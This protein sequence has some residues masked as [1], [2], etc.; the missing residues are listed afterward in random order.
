MSGNNVV[1]ELYASNKQLNVRVNT[2]HKKM[3]NDNNEM[4]TILKDL[5]MNLKELLEQNKKILEKIEISE[6]TDEKKT[7]FLNN[8]ISI[9]K[10][11]DE[12]KY[13]NQID[14]KNTNNANNL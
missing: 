13:I 4:I 6:G 5:G 11:L 10:T 14:I 9:D 1:N 8:K 12:L 3:E 7:F 2:I